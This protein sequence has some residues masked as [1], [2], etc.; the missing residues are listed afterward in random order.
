MGLAALAVMV[1]PLA[2][3]SMDELWRGELGV[4]LAQYQAV[5]QRKREVRKLIEMTKS[6]GVNL[7]LKLGGVRQTNHVSPEGKN[8][9]LE[10][11]LRRTVD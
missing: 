3:V 1:K 5:Q 6:S 2:E 8:S 9:W 10:N 4:E 11:E 7:S